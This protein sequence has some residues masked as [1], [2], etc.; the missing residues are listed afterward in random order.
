LPRQLA[1]VFFFHPHKMGTDLRKST[2]NCRV[3]SCE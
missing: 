1:S 3:N 2:L